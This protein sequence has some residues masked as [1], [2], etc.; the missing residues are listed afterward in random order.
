MGGLRPTVH[1]FRGG[2]G[3]GGGGRTLR[4]RTGRQAAAGAGLRA[5]VVGLAQFAAAVLAGVR[6]GLLL[7]PLS[8]REK[9]QLRA[10][11]VPAASL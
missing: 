3:V 11:G 6:V 8:A 5:D 4:W 1:G 2:Q 7:H 10:G 9:A